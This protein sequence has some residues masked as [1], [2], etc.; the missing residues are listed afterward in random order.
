[1]LGSIIC[2]C[3]WV[4]AVV[5]Y[6]GHETRVSLQNAPFL[7]FYARPSSIDDDGLYKAP[8]RVILVC[9]IVR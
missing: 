8:I 3:D 2:G 1:M 7:P 4:L 5:V 6:T 9:F